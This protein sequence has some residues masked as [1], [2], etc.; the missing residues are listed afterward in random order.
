MSAGVRLMMMRNLLHILGGVRGESPA[1]VGVRA[2]GFYTLRME[3]GD[4]GLEML[5]RARVLRNYMLKDGFEVEIRPLNP[6]GRYKASCTC[7][8]AADCVH[9]ERLALE[10]L[11]YDHST[12]GFYADASASD[13]EEV[14]R[15]L[16]VFASVEAGWAVGNAAWQP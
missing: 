15:L 9:I 14:E 2:S 7:S 8:P 11:R 16:E 1:S 6:H 12:P 3:P 5:Y 10:A 4:L 13:K